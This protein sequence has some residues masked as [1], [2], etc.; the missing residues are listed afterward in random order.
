MPLRN[1]E[2]GSEIVIVD[3]NSIPKAIYRTMFDRVVYEMIQRT[4]NAFFGDSFKASKASANSITVKKGT[5]FLTDNTQASPESTKR[6][7]HLSS[8]QNVLIDTPDSVNNRIDV[9]CVRYGTEDELTGS[10]KVKD[11]TSS[12]ITTENLVVQKDFKA[13]IQ[14]VSGTPGLSPVAP[15]TPSGWLKIAEILVTA[16]AGIVNTNDV[17]DNRVLV[18]IGGSATVDTTGFDR[19][20]AG[21]SISIST[22]LA[23]IDAFLKNGFQ[24]Y[25]DME[26]LN[27]DPAAPSAGNQRFYIKNG[28]AYLRANAGSPVPLG[29]GSGGGGGGAN[30]Q[31]VAGLGPIEDFEYD[32][33]IWKFEKDGLQAL[34]LWVKVPNSYLAGRQVSMKS[35]FYSPGNSDNWR[36]QMRS[37]LIRKNNDA[38]TSVANQEISNSGDFLNAVADRMREV[39]LTCSTALGTINGVAISPGDIIKL[40]L[41]RIAPGGTED[42]SDLRFIPS[43]TEVLF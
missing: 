31:P 1:F 33:K 35:A 12:V 14:V 4:E 10:R 17:S 30:W 38:V 32:E 43:S 34:T 11:A 23:E 36:V 19:L 25:T 5:G 28:V 8:D 26:D 16:V 41:S 40:E 13:E 6:I 27:A 22:L 9:V 37:T 21:G 29:S 20:T 15:A 18:P 42:A 7:L 3:F 2:D 24:E 39:S